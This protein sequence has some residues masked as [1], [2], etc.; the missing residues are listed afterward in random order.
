VEVEDW[1]MALQLD[2]ATRKSNLDDSDTILGN[3]KTGALR[4]IFALMNM[5]NLFS[6]WIRDSS[7]NLFMNGL[8]RR[9]FFRESYS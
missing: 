8:L 6:G 4:C 1:D 3:D 5:L 7:V 9:E 2:D